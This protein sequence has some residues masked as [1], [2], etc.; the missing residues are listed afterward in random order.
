MPLVYFFTNLQMHNPAILPGCPSR[1]VAR[2]EFV[3]NKSIAFLQIF[4]SEQLLFFLLKTSGYNVK[5]DGLWVR[6]NRSLY[7]RCGPIHID[8]PVTEPIVSQNKLSR[9]GSYK[10]EPSRVSVL[11]FYFRSLDYANFVQYQE[12]F[13]D[14][15]CKYYCTAL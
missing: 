10:V 6:S 5:C 3:N 15:L 7:N 12:K 14:F 9:E 4:V 2:N 11:Q 1:K 13:S 8:H